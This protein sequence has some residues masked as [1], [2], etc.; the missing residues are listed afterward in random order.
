[1]LTQSQVGPV[2]A[3]GGSSS[4]GKSLRPVVSAASTAKAQRAVLPPEAL[5]LPVGGV[6]HLNLRDFLA[7]GANGL[8]IGSAL[9][10]L[11]ISMSELKHNA[12]A[13]LDACAGTMRV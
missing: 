10:N 9:C 4:A 13:F 5:V 3:A 7:A 12:Q 8:G 1:M 11:G 2:Q 6:T